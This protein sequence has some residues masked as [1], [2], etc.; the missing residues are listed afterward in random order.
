MIIHPRRTQDALNNNMSKT[1]AV[2]GVLMLDLEGISLSAFEQELLQRPAVGGLILFSRNFVSVNQ[3]RDLVAAIRECRPGILIAVDQ[4]GGRVQRLREGFLPLPSLRAIAQVALA[5]PAY[6]AEI[7]T[8]CGWAMAAE[9]LHYGIDF[10]FAPVLDLYHE[11]SPVIRERAFSMNPVEVTALARAYIEGMHQ[12]GMAATGKHF[13]GHGTVA[14]DSHV[15]LPTD[16]RSFAAIAATDYSTFVGCLDVLDAIM[17]AHVLYPQV[18]EYCAGFSEVW[19]QQLLRTELGFD[20]VVF[21]DDLSMVAAHGAGS[22]PQRAELALKAGCDMLLVCNDRAGAL[23][24]ADWLESNR[25]QGHSRLLR[26]RAQPAAGIGD[27]FELPQ[28]RAATQLLATIPDG[29][30]NKN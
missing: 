11:D 26:M 7:V 22:L 28:W 19:I 8:T 3:L 18:D 14:A 16:N 5:K 30:T 6:T 13:P 17:P 4:E 24:V 1:I 10:S 15:A 12:A 20:G 27:L 9:L 2:P 21:S 23:T 25:I 29:T